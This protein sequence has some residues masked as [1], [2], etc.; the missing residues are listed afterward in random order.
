[1]VPYGIN[2]VSEKTNLERQSRKKE[3]EKKEKNKT[4]PSYS[5]IVV[6]N[7]VPV[8]NVDVCFPM[9]IFANMTTWTNV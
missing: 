4:I 5:Q 6:L 3:Q 8:C 1:M 7:L 2:S 9:N